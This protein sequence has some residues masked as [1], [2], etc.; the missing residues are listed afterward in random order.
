MK[1]IELFDYYTGR[2]LALL[3]ANFP[4]KIDIVYNKDFGEVDERVMAGTISWLYDS[5]FIEYD[6]SFLNSSL[7]TGVRL[8]Y[9]GLELLKQKPSSLNTQSLGDELTD[10]VKQGAKELIATHTKAI[11]S[12]GFSFVSKIIKGE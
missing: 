6:K 3:Y 7:I 2:I 4:C 12:L 10:S 11:L 9:K 8:S 5:G 1:N